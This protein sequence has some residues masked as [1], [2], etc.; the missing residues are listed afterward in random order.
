MILVRLAWVRSAFPFRRQESE[1]AG[2]GSPLPTPAFAPAV[3]PAPAPAPAAPAAPEVPK[4]VFLGTPKAEFPDFWVGV[5]DQA[6]TF[7]ALNKGS[8]T[9]PRKRGAG[10][11]G[12]FAGRGLCWSRP[13]TLAASRGLDGS[14]W[15]PA[16]RRN[17]GLLGD[18]GVCSE[19]GLFKGGNCVCVK[20]LDDPQ[21]GW[22]FPP[23]PLSLKRVPSLATQIRSVAALYID[24]SD[25]FSWITEDHCHVLDS[26]L[27]LSKSGIGHQ[28]NPKRQSCQPRTKRK[29]DHP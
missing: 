6:A 12:G 27:W 14:I 18:L 19:N 1:E 8:W 2:A 25:L 4:N 5:G 11:L 10:Q 26:F 16:S 28:T 22:V 20:I 23:V 7:C 3:A 13:G 29:A 17:Q 9:T 24:N 15:L 21:H